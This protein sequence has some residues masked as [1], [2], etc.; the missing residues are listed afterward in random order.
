MEEIISAAI[1]KINKALDAFIK[2]SLLTYHGVD[3]AAFDTNTMDGLHKLKAVIDRFGITLRVKP[4]GIYELVSNN[5][6]PV[7]GGPF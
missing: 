1:D 7:I 5:R 4:D 2:E 3:V 6:P